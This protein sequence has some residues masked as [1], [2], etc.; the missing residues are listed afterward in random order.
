MTSRTNSQA[1]AAAL[2]KP[3]SL[4]P[5]TTVAFMEQS[6]DHP[7]VVAI[8]FVGSMVL[9]V[10]AL[11][12]YARLFIDQRFGLDDWLALSTLVR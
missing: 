9:L 5:G 11:R 2:A 12:C 4:P 3:D 7:T 8:L 1:I 10:V 6:R